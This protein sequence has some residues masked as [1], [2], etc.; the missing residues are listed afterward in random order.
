MAET[1]ENK[2]FIAISCKPLAG[3]RR[4][5]ITGSGLQWFNALMTPMRA[6]IV[7]HAE[8]RHENQ[9]F[10]RRLPLRGL[11]LGLRKPRDVVAGVS[12]GDQLPTLRQ[13]NRC[14]EL[15]PTRTR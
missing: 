4:G 10:H 1:D 3:L 5:T 6:N 12:H 8:R 9:H 7:G 14:I 11:V 13:G 2:K 15:K